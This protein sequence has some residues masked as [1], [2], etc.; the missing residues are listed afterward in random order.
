MTR[1]SH[2]S[3]TQTDDASFF[4]ENQRKPPLDIAV[5]PD[6]GTI[7]YI[8]Y[9]IQDEKIKNMSVIPSIKNEYV[10]IRI[11]DKMFNESNMNITINGNFK[12]LKI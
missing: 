12:A 8:S 2:I 9:F 3:F 1:G 10:R 7:E 11:T 6:D 5:N 4:Y